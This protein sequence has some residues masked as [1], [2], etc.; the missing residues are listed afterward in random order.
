MFDS[1]E[2]IHDFLV[3]NHIDKYL[4]ATNLYDAKV[5]NLTHGTP[6]HKVWVDSVTYCVTAYR[7]D[8]ESKFTVEFVDYM[9]SL[10][11]LEH[12][13]GVEQLTPSENQD[14]IPTYTS[15]D[16]ILDKINNYGM[17]SLTESE[18]QILQSQ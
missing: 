9:N 14:Q 17:E 2:E 10:E 11:P 8:S 6:I 1:Q 12:G 3:S 13:Q 16:D 7:T 15:I 18:L 5:G 4:T